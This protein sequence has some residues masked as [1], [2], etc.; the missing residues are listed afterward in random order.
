MMSLSTQVLQIFKK[1]QKRDSVTKVKAFAELSRYV[2][3]IEPQAEEFPNLLTFFL[4]HMTSILS[5]EN[6]K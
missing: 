5:N 3:K 1:L 6:D 4:Y 2:G